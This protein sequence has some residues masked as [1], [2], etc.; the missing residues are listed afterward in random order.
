MGVVT[1]DILK[2]MVAGLRADFMTAYQRRIGASIVPQ[3]AT[4]VPTTLPTQDYAWLGQVPS[5]REWVD[6]RVHK[7]LKSYNWSITDRTWEATLDISRRALEDDQYG[8][9]RIRINDLA[10]AAALHREKIVVQQYALGATVVGPDGQYLIDTDHDESGSNQSNKTTSALDESTLS[11]AI[12]AMQQFTDNTGELLGITPTH[13]LVGPKLQFT[14]AKL[15]Q[16]TTNVVIKPITADATGA[17]IGDRNVLEG[18]LQLVIS[19]Y[20]TGTYDDY[21]FVIDGSRGM[22]GVILQERSDVPMEFVARDDPRSSE[23]AYERDEY[24]YGVRARYN[25]GFGLWQTVYGGIL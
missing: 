3:I 25:V 22:K 14:A 18:L 9:L 24:S 11:A 6:E 4:V 19:P 1:S 23:A 17:M 12:S 13:L 16:S 10:G 8:M 7:A 21:W 2:L 5:M 15:L 20:L